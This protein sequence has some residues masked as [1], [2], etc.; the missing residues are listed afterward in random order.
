MTTPARSGVVRSTTLGIMAGN[1]LYSPVPAYPSQASAANVQG[2]VRVEADVDRNGNV[3][4]A[5]VISGPALLR[6]AA[7]EA[8]Q[9]WRY[10]PFLAGGKPVPVSAVNVLEFELQ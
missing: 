1:T 4:A 2:Q 3:A 5:R 10:R 7:L 6:D 8:V 9:H